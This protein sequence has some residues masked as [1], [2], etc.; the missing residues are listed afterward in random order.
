M[1]ASS[2]PEVPLIFENYQYTA[3][4]GA[5]TIT[6]YTGTSK[7]LTVPGTIEGMPVIRIENQAFWGRSSLKEVI[8]S[9]GVKNIGV[10]AFRTCMSLC[11]VTLPASIVS[12]ENGA[13][14]GCW[15]LTS[16]IFKGNAPVFGKEVFESVARSPTIYYPDDAE[17]WS[18]ILNGQPTE[19][20]G[21][22]E[23]QKSGRILAGNWHAVKRETI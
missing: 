12:I 6:R 20:W 16:V 9:D 5:V 18:K 13:F 7:L 14:Y 11:K 21:S 1:S 4:N 19:L 22:I 10:F 2:P 3:E 8:I 15:H 17:G 23:D